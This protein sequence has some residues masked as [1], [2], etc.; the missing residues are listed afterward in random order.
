[1]N[2]LRLLTV[3]SCCFYCQVHA[4]YKNT[5]EKICRKFRTRKLRKACLRSL[6]STENLRPALTMED[7]H[8]VRRHT[9]AL[10]PPGGLT[11]MNINPI[12]NG[13]GVSLN[14]TTSI[15]CPVDDLSIAGDSR[16]HIRNTSPWDY[17]VHDDPT[18]YE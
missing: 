13:I 15:R 9:V 2:L 18:R 10:V 14:C 8:G 3:F 6:G 16:D 4:S 7:V 12:D 11:E 17:C 5:D 1:M